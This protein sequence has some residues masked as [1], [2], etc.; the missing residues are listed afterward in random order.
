MNTYNTI[1]TTKDELKDILA[2]LKTYAHPVLKEASLYQ[3]WGATT[4][5]RVKKDRVI[6]IHQ[7]KI[8]KRKKNKWEPY[9]NWYGAF[10]VPD[11]R[12]KGHATALYR[13]LEAFAVDAGC[14]RVKSLAGSRAGL[15]LHRS[16][17][18]QCWGWTKN[19]EIFVDSPLPGAE[20]Y[21]EPGEPP[22]Q[23]P[24]TLMHAAQIEHVIARG[25]RYDK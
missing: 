15:A 7:S 16:L 6:S 5:V 2:G 17:K 13:Q 1:V 21:Y 11:E 22:A 10:T 3:F 20:G 18:H 4:L 24:S 12:R 25:L 9:M 14:R 8:G 23:A 19:D